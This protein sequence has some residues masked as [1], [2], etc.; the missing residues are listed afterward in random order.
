MNVIVD[1]VY[2]ILLRPLRPVELPAQL[3]VEPEMALRR[4]MWVGSD[5]SPDKSGSYKILLYQPPVG[6]RFS[7]R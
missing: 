7:A 6:A 4:F 1:L 5:P 2:F 3:Q